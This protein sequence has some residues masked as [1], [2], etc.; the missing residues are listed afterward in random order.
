[1]ANTALI[2]SGLDFDSIR[3][4]LRT[5]IASKPDFVD[6]DFN[7]SAIGTLLDLLAYNTY[8]TSYYVNMAV[9]ESFLDSAIIRDSVVS[10]AKM[11]GYIP[12]SVQGPTANVKISFTNAVKSATKTTITIPKNTQFTASINGV[13]YRFVTPQ[14]YLVEANNTNGFAR[15]IDIVEGTPITDLYTY[16]TAA[17]SFV[18]PNDNVDTRSISVSVTSG[19]NTQTYNL[20]SDI[21]AINSSSK[22]FFVEPDKDERYKVV[23]GDN[24]LGV[25]P[26][27]NSTV[28]ISYRV[29]N[30]TRANGANNFSSAGIIGSES[31]YTLRTESRASGGT[32]LESISSIKYNAPRNYETQ[33]RAVTIKDYE[34]I[35]LRDNGD[36]SAVTVW[37]GEENDPPIYGK[38]FASVKPVSGITFSSTRKSQI[39]NALK[40]FNVVSI[41]TELVDPTYLYIIPT[42][43]V[44]YDP[45][46]TSSSA[47]QIASSIASRVVAYETNVLNTFDGKF[48][49][50]KFLQYIESANPAIVGSSATINL[51]LRFVPSTTRKNNY[52]FKF[53]RVLEK[54]NREISG[55]GNLY[56]NK[57]L[58]K[59]S[60]SY[61][62]DF[63]GNVRAYYVENIN[64]VAV[65]T[66]SD[67]TV[68]TVNYTTGSVSLT[69]F[70]PSS[71]TT[72][73]LSINVKPFDPNI[74]P[75]RNQILLL[76]DVR[77][78][79]IDDNTET[80][81]ATS[82]SIA[83]I[84]NSA[85]YETEN[86]ALT[87]I[88]SY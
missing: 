39:R 72:D 52:T 44:R 29:S 75:V 79:V 33:N 70:Q 66:Y 8:Y 68:G 31:V 5:F 19:G 12:R 30:G 16:T 87:N 10:R 78:T 14:S 54:Y 24:V 36:V 62:D 42:I 18:V 28:A 38:V 86:T 17:T 57:F 61:L 85:F 67:T 25:R 50:S 1:M 83:T 43:T 80:I 64:G 48:R 3:S 9:N 41:D 15:Y 73:Y 22:I 69:E 34:R 53:N 21:N 59:G 82:D 76:S 26:N 81:A 27:Y 23:F 63:D 20:A 35:I 58:Y 49:Y 47:S 77:I 88:T 4:N 13:S 84:G 74:E 37:G 55:I 60:D 71:F 2:V 45:T 40:Q 11:L 56:S 46:S 7:D 6:F 65:R 32:D 51:Q